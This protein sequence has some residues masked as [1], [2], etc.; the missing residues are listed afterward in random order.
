VAEL[1]GAHIVIT[2]G[3]SGIGLATARRALA[4]D[5]EQVVVAGRDAKR[6]AAATAHLGSRSTPL[7]LDVTDESAVLHALQAVGPFDHLVTAAAGNYRATFPELDT[8]AA[9]QLFESKFWGQHHCVRRGA[10]LLRPGGSITLFSGWISRKPAPGTSTLA[11]I[12][13]AIEA[14]ARVLSLE[15]APLRVNAVSPGAIDT[16][17]WAAQFTSEQQREYFAR[18]AQLTP[19]GRAGHADDVAHAV[20]FLMTNGFTSGSVVDIDGGQR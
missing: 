9:R 19:V 6:L 16:P 1:T 5:A 11:A 17:R 12:D 8:A 20:T 10:P 15:L 7:V 4:L 18:V 14:L 3:S 2:G 13:G